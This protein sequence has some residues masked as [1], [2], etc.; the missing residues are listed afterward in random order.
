M[1]FLIQTFEWW[2]PY[3]ANEIRLLATHVHVKRFQR[4]D[5]SNDVRKINVM[6]MR[7]SGI[8]IKNQLEGL[9]MTL[10]WKKQ[11]RLMEMLKH[12]LGTL[13]VYS[14]VILLNIPTHLIEIRYLLSEI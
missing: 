7:F 8:W 6:H 13:Y 1:H 9:R 2:S 11:S 5:G 4:S 10:E 14:F 3:D 12:F